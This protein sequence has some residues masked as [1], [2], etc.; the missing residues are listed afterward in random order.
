VRAGDGGPLSN[1]APLP[2]CFSAGP[3]PFQRPFSL[4]SPSL[5]GGRVDISSPT[6]RI[7][8][9]DCP[10]HQ[11]V[12]LAFAPFL[13]C[14]RPFSARTPVNALTTAR[15]NRRQSADPQYALRRLSRRVISTLAVMP[16]AGGKHDRITS[17]PRSR[18][19]RI[20]R[21]TTLTRCFSDASRT[22][23]FHWCRARS[24]FG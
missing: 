23:L 9:G 18:T 7:H 20:I 19:P 1:V 13:A 14:S 12:R 17:Q 21:L 22:L 16:A 6:S 8:P 24:R 15:R 4:I 2:H 5:R 3:S 11:L 10:P